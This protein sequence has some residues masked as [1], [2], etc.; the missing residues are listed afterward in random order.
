M[1]NLLNKDGSIDFQTAIN[2]LTNDSNPVLSS[3]QPIVNRN[4]SSFVYLF[5]NDLTFLLCD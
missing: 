4:C 3:I 2:S 1:S 5:I